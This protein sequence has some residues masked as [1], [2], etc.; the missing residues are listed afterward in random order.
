MCWTGG[1]AFFG[2]TLAQQRADVVNVSEV[3]LRTNAIR[4]PLPSYPPAS[5][6]KKIGGV[7]VVSIITDSEGAPTS[8]TVLEAPDEAIAAIVPQTVRTWTFA[9][10]LVGAQMTK[11]GFMGKLTFYFQAS[12]RGGRVLNPQD[13][14][15]GPVMPS[16]RGPS[17]APTGPP[18]SRPVVS[19]AA[20]IDTAWTE[21]GEPEL[22]KLQ[23][24][25]RPIVLD[26]RPR[27][28]FSRGHRTG[29]VNIPADELAV[30]AGIELDKARPVVVDCSREETRTCQRAAATLKAGTFNRILIFL[31]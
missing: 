29:A 26:I 28:D 24:A 14:P 5:L 2:V 20:S 31:P 10:A 30:R 12:D 8:V 7:V 3:V 18:P 1:L 23:L 16:H 25:E 22:K 9:P 13:M 17:G 11:R 4:S 19:D 15:G 6:A 21:I 27:S